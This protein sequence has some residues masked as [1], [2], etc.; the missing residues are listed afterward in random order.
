MY[1]IPKELDLTPII[2][3]FTTQFRVG[4]FDFQFSIGKVSFS[5][6]STISIYKDNDLCGQWVS[7]KWPD[8]IFY[9]LFNV[10]VTNW[11]RLNENTL[12][13]SFANG[14]EMYLVDETDLYESMIITINEEYWVI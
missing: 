12:I 3:D 6:Y 4:P 2:S 7:G 10:E 8:K 9:D 14:L 11:Q 5:I 13:I 1:R